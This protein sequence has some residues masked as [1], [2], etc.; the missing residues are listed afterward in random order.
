VHLACTVSDK[1]PRPVLLK[2]YGVGRDVTS[3]T[4]PV[5]EKL[6]AVIK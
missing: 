5:R 1:E 3:A 2:W 6:S 4:L